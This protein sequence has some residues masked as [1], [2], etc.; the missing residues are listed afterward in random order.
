MIEEP[1][2]IVQ[3]PSIE[4]KPSKIKKNWWI[5]VSLIAIFFLVLTLNAYFNASS[6]VS[7]NNSGEGLDKYYLSG[8][9]PYYNMRIVEQTLYGEEAGI[10]PF[11]SVEDPLLNYPLGRTGHRAPL[12]NMLAIG[13]SSFLTPFM[14]EIDAVGYSMQFIPALFGALLI[15]PVYFIGNTLFGKKAGLLAALFIAIIPIHLSSGHGSAYS[16]FDHDSFNLLMYVLTFLF[17]I[18]G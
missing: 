17:I 6:G 9:D 16:L 1:K 8:P 15:F 4:I 13:F 5:T 2:H 18:W 3:K 10:Y 11:Y 12:L 14:E 7:I